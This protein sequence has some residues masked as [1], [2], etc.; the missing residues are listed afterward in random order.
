MAKFTATAST[1]SSK[2]LSLSDK[3][4]GFLISFMLILSTARRIR[5]SP[6]GSAAS[7]TNSAAP[8]RSAR[9][10][11]KVT[12]KRTA[13]AKAKTPL[14]NLPLKILIKV[15]PLRNSAA[16]ARCLAS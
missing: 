10:S 5:A 3:I 7:V 11:A 15:P 9:P 4:L 2:I 6:A 13:P 1:A 16:L 14:I 12:L 8:R